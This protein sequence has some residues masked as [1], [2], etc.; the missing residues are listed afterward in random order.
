[1]MTLLCFYLKGINVRYNCL[2]KAQMGSKVKD[3]YFLLT[4]VL[5][6]SKFFLIFHW[7]DD[8]LIYQKKEM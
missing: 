8:F 7:I 1:M 5:V 3:I 6:N 4:F 2:Q